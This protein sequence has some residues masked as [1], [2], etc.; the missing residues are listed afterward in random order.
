MQEISLHAPI[1]SFHIGAW[2]IT[3][4]CTFSAFWINFLR[5]RNL[6][7]TRT[8]DFLGDD[9]VIKLDFV[10]HVTGIIGLIGIILAVWTCFV[11]ASTITGKTL[12]SVF[13]INV[14]LNGV[15]VALAS[16]LLSFKML[17][18]VVGIQI[19]LFAGLIRLYFVT[20]KKG[21]TVYDEHLT[22]QILYSESTL[23]A[24]VV[25]TVIGAVG[26]LYATGHTVVADIPIIQDFLP[27]GNL[28]IVFLFFAAF[29]AVLIV[30]GTI[31]KEQSKVENEAVT[32][33]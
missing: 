14:I 26:G 21:R 7:P 22:I 8:N 24:Y 30:V 31:L 19:F 13:D 17:W 25:I 18:T 5:K 32:K 3:A 9:V 12:F 2:A 28:L 33:K 4:L 6:I 1:L 11:D 29:F 16:E 20:Y 10:A 23:I 15:N 27:G